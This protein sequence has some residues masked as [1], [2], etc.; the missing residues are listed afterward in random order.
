MR[1]I[2]VAATHTGMETLC[3]RTEVDRSITDTSLSTRGY[4][5]H[6]AHTQIN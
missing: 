3:P 1:C 4:S 5:F 6:L 2:A